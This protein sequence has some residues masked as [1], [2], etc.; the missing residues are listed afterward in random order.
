MGKNTIHIKQFQ[1]TN[2]AR[3]CW[4]EE[5]GRGLIEQDGFFFKDMAGD[6]VLYPYE[7]WRLSAE[8]RAE[9]LAQR[10]T[11]EQIAGLMLYSKHQFVPGL[12]SSYFGTVTYGGKDFMES[13]EPVNA[14]SDQQKA[15]LEDDFLRHVLVV[16]VKSA[17]DSAEWNN[18][19][20]S[21]AEGLPWGIPVSISSDPRHG[22][23]VS[24][25]FDA[26]AGGDISQ[27]PEPLGLAATFDPKLVKR[28]GEIAARE[29]R[30]L[31]I[32]TALSPQVDLCTEPRWSRFGGSFGESPKL[33]ADLARAYCDGFQTSEGCW[34]IKDG[35]G[36]D[37]VNTMVKHWPG[38]GAVEGGRD[39]HFACG[40][41]SVYPGGCFDEHLKPFTE[42][43]FKL[44]G[45]TE[46]ASAVMPYYTIIYGKAG[47]NENVG[48]SYNHYLITDL[49]REKYGYDEVVCTD[50]GITGDETEPDDMYSGK[51]WGVEHL[52]Q[53]QR[54]YKILMAGVDQFGG[55]NESAP[56]LKAYQMGIEEHG[57]AFMQRRM[58]QSAKRLLRNMIRIGL[59]ENPYVDPEWSEKTVGCPD[60]MKEGFEAQLKSIVLLKNQEHTLPLSTGI[61]IYVP[62]LHQPEYTDWMGIHAEETWE[63]PVAVDLLKKYAILVETPEEADAAICFIRQ[64]GAAGF[65]LL[66]GYER[67]DREAGGN[68]YVPVSLQYR[69]YIAKKARAQSIAGGDPREDFVNRSYMGKTVSVNNEEDLEIV[70][71]TRERMGNKPVIVCLKMTGPMVVAEVEPQADAMLAVFG[72]LPQAALEIIFG[73]TEPSGLLPMQLPANMDTVEEQMED[74]PFDMICYKDNQGNEYDFGF[75]MNFKGVIQ[76]YR[77]KTYGHPGK[78]SGEN[79]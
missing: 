31:G 68:G 6:G 15:F 62:K 75:G 44:E 11:I 20:Q 60:Y 73:R 78:D 72:Q 7:D 53:E 35:W 33:S 26:G 63:D 67:K 21:L 40:K 10:L 37:S 76:D 56:I 25:E 79:E 36:Y 74:A 23:T 2:G 28:F 30:A 14:L 16:A 55:L 39:A 12:G 48:C 13:G 57:E 46:K 32:T 69:P 66:G 41:Y 18:R 65:S 51:C 17:K 22:T 8:K 45:K 64:P 49:L 52:S 29:Y 77:T 43:A 27:W 5:S 61:K 9:D 71:N 42:G 1:N 19:L 58:R 47:N 38:G 59:F 34:E 3:L 50:W 70:E 54:C 24:F 4:S